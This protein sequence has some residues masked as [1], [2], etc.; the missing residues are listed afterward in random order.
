MGNKKDEV[1]VDTLNKVKEYIEHTGFIILGTVSEDGRPAL[2]TIAS[3]ANDQFDIY[4]S[5]GKQSAK[6]GHI[7]ANPYVTILFQN[8]GQEL[9]T[10]KNVTYHGK[11]KI[12][13]DEN[14]LEKG[15]RLLC[16]KNPW[17][18]A[19]VEAGGLQGISIF[20]VEPES[21]QYLDYS[22]GIG[23]AAIIDLLV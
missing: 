14:G 18:K 9:T 20:K 5:T 1:Q 2:R 15:V 13:S 11:A 21:I 10:F 17:F 12:V 16:D 6:V 7:K 8:E 4:F 19:T 22:K 3:F 23:P